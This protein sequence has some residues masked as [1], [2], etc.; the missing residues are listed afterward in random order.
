MVDVYE[1]L[2]GRI[3]VKYIGDQWLLF[4]EG[5]YLLNKEYI[6]KFKRLVDLIVS[7]ICLVMTAP[8]MGLITRGIRL[9]SSGPILYRQKRVGKGEQNFA[10]LKFRTMREDAEAG[11]VRW[12]SESDPRVTRVG[13]WLRLIHMDEL[14]Q[15][16][17]VFK[18][19]MSLI[20]PRPER[21][22]FVKMLR[23]EVPYY[24]VRHSASR[25]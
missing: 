7:A 11:G 6:Q 10:I 16:W 2:T 9:E 20:G 4:A 8:L 19:D 17:N 23:S 24:F 12:A 13:R 14:P 18:G 22:E 21:P 5:F 15:L 25:A 3:P 1:Q